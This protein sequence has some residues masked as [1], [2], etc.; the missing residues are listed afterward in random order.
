MTK[1]VSDAMTTEV[2]TVT[3]D[4]RFK[5]IVSLL[6]SHHVNLIP[7]ID[8]ERRVLGIVSEADLLTKVGWADRVPPGR[9]ERWFK[10]AGELRRVEGILASEIMTRA[11]DT[12]T[13]EMTVSDAA[14]EMTVS[15]V[16]VLPV[17]DEHERLVGIVSRTDLLK[18]FVREDASIQR[19]VVEGVL[20]GALAIEPEA[21]AAVVEDG[22]VVLLGEVESR[23][24]H[25]IIENMVGAVPGV[26][27]VVNRLEYRADGHL[28][29]ASRDLAVTVP[30][31]AD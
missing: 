14:Q 24:L 3:P 17:V 9:I 29:E 6:E 8:D 1:Q 18:T 22:A 5:T 20:R 15:E 28:L 11:V 2:V 16:K 13:P 7:V 23:G 4:T 27:S 31:P 25:D 26:I 30:T 19:E 10:A 12:I 21:V